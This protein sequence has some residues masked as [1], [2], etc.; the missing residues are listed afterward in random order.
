[1]HRT[2]AGIAGAAALAIAL[3]GCG[4]TGDGAKAAR[5]SPATS[6]LAVEAFDKLKFDADAFSAS[7]GCV[8]IEYT[9]Q[10]SLAHTLLIKGQAGFKL[11][12]GTRASGSIDLA[13]G[14]YRLYCDLPGHESAGMHAVLTVS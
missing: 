14:T 10:G 11:S 12:I 4:G 7:A 5:C 2:I 9:N 8:G 1:M 13:P 3:A 6:N